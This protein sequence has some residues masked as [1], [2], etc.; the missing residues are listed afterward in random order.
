MTHDF[1]SLT[2]EQLQLLYADAN[3]HLMESLLKGAEWEEVR[4][5]R[6]KV[7]C[8]AREIHHRKYP[9]GKTP[10]ETAFRFDY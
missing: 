5:E 4:E 10:A 6:I 9:L 3:S 7:T 8:I 2:L 1:S